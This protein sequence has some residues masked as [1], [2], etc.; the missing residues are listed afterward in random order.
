[1]NPGAGRDPIRRRDEILQVMYWMRG[2]GLAGAASAGDFRLFLEPGD[3]DG[4]GLEADLEGLVAAG[5]LERAGPRRYRLTERGI[6]EGGRRFADEF[7]GL[8]AQGHGACNDP[9]CDC[10][11]EGPEACVNSR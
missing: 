7:A 3:S 11:V 4:S 2:E 10:H 9:T 5:F 1:M 6:E 8:T